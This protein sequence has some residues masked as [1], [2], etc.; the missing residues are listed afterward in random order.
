MVKIRHMANTFRKIYKKTGNSG[1]SSDYELVGNIGVNGVELDIMQG[2][3]SG[4]D[5]EIGLVP[6]PTSGQQNM[7]LTGDGDWKDA[8]SLMSNMRGYDIITFLQRY[9]FQ[10]GYA[11]TNNINGYFRSR[12]IV[13]DVPYA[14]GFN[15]QFTV[16]LSIIK[17][18]MNLQEYI[19]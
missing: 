13:F 10:A 7:V 3:S 17:I 1:S 16:V 2:A 19:L 14:E 18:V 8:F 15:Q 4:A 5:G 11:S 9:F 12:T 6:K